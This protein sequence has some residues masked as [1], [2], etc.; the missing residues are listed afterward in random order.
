MKINHYTMTVNLRDDTQ[1]IHENVYEVSVDQGVVGMSD[2]E[3]N[4]W[5]YPIDTIK[6]ITSRQ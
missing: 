5:V 1:I 6:S 2:N 4:K 3:G